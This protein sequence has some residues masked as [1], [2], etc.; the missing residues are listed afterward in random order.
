M[1]RPTSYDNHRQA[2]IVNIVQREH[3][4]CSTI[5]VIEVRLYDFLIFQASRPA[6]G[7]HK[8]QIY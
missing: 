8:Y 5:G 1:D 2:K 7:L 6:I 4:G 3:T